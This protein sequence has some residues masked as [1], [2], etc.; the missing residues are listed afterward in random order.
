MSQQQ[1]KGDMNLI[2]ALYRTCGVWKDKSGGPILEGES[3]NLDE[4]FEAVWS[5]IENTDTLLEFDDEQLIMLR[6][7]M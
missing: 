7:S 2:R 4:T 5:N 6:Q 1:T 3:G